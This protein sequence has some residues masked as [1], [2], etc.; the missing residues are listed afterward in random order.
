MTKPT[1]IAEYIAAAP[2]THR[3]ALKKLKAQ[4]KKLYPKTTEHIAYG[5][6]LF[7]HNGHPLAAFSA[8]KKHIGFFVWSGTA[9]AT[10]GTLLKGYDTGVGVIRFAPDSS[11]PD[12]VIKGVLKAREAEIKKRWPESSS[13]P[14]PASKRK[15]RK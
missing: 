11:L 9:F 4:I 7:K 10:L 6:P 15:T 8:H 1:T 5:A 3:P 2:A 12:K 14:V 13:R